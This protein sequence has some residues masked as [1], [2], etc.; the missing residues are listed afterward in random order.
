MVNKR[1]KDEDFFF[2]GVPVKR[3]G[4]KKKRRRKNRGK[5]VVTMEIDNLIHPSDKVE[6]F[7][8]LKITIPNFKTEVDGTIK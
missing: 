6:L 2:D 1:D 3:R 7:E 4:G 5:K 8:E